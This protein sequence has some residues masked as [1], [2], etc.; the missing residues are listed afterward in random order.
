MGAVDK[1]ATIIWRTVEVRGSKEIDAI[2]TP[3]ITADEIGNGHY[4]DQ[5]N[6]HFRQFRQLSAGGFPGAL[7]RKGAEVH[8]ID[9]L[10]LEVN[11]WPCLI[12]PL[13]CIGINDLGRAMRPVWLK[14]RGWIWI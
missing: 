9:Y 12:S 13:E 3:A 5:R 8:L 11:T 2:I 14:T 6:A 4:L 10:S 7:G 1:P